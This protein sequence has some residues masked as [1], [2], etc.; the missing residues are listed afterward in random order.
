[1][2][3]TYPAFL[4]LL[5]FVLESLNVMYRKYRFLSFNLGFERC[6]V[7]FS[8]LKIVCRYVMRSAW[9]SCREPVTLSQRRCCVPRWDRLCM[10][11]W[12]M[13]LLLSDAIYHFTSR[14][15][16]YGGHDWCCRCN[17]VR[18]VPA[19]YMKILFLLR[20]A[21]YKACLARVVLLAC[22]NTI[23]TQDSE[24]SNF[25]NRTKCQKSLPL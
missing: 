10:V 24:C 15:L 6:E 3:A 16:H 22:S 20:Q 11:Q 25:A 12:M 2:Y 17:E 23:I 4:N 1:M 9:H 8:A 19:G 5:R 7:S 18:L 14:C 13:D 21:Y